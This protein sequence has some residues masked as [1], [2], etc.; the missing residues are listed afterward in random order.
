MST[1]L[2]GS[3]NLARLKNVGIMSVKGKTE[4]KK[5]V[6]I[7]IDDNDIY[8]KVED[9]VTQTGEAYTSTIYSLGIE[10]YE[11]READQ[12]GNVCYAKLGASK[13]WIDHHT[14]KELEE[15]NNVYLGN[16]KA[17][18]LPSSNQAETIE[19]PAITAEEDDALPF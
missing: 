16:F 5:C 18:N 2:I 8:C 13:E 7:P 11:K 12:Y 9:K 17:I 3:L 15:R 6:V 14:P 10:I 19:A 4:T 1:K